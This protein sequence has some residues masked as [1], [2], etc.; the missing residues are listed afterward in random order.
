MAPASNCL[1]LILAFTRESELVFRLA[2]RDLVDTEPLVGGA[3]KTRQMAFDILDVV[4]LVGKRVVHINDDDLPVSLFLVEESHD[5]ENL[6]LLDLASVTDQLANFADVERIVVALSLGLW[7]NN[8]G[9][10]PG[11]S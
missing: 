5:T 10:F 8:V 2:I 6:D 7:V 3:E 1:L 11:L 4:E 9:V